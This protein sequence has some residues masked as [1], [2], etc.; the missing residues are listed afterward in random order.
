MNTFDDKIVGAT[1]GTVP[2]N[3]ADIG[4][5]EKQR[6]QPLPSEMKPNSIEELGGVGLRK[7]VVSEEELDQLM[8]DS[9]IELMVFSDSLKFEKHESSGRNV[10]SLVD[11][12]TK[13]VIKQFP[14]DEFL[15]VSI[16]LK[17][18]LENRVVARNDSNSIGNLISSRI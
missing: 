11:S 9:N 15:Q 12:E 14:A 8:N 10:Y 2:N 7:E 16:D 4:V 18:Y 6:V 1:Y 5:R 3:N 13:T 17:E